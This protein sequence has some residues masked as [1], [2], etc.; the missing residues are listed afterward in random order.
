VVGVSAVNFPAHVTKGVVPIN[1]FVV[2]TFLDGTLNHEVPY[3]G[4]F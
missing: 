2:Y 3:S 4:L 1:Y